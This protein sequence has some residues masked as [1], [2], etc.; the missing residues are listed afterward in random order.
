MLHTA[1][2]E[3]ENNANMQQT[4]CYLVQQSPAGEGYSCQKSFLQGSPADS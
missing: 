2:E 4:L 3:L 1:Y